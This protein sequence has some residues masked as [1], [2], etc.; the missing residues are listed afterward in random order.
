MGFGKIFSDPNLIG[1][2]ASN[3]RTQKHLADPA[4]VQQVCT[5]QIY[6]S[7]SRTSPRYSQLK[8]MQNNPSMASMYV[9]LVFTNFKHFSQWFKG[10]ARSSND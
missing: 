6:S 1:K 3:P 10:I 9:S 2:L 8:L 7:K 4:F 5:T